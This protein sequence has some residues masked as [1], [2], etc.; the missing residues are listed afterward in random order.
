MGKATEHLR[1]LIKKQLKNHGIVVCYDPEGVYG[2]F[3]ESLSIP[4]TTVL[5]WKDS[6]FRL[7]RELDAFLEFIGEDGR[8]DP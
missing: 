7:R 3:S 5:R 2:E 6:F 1:S 4:D 8:P